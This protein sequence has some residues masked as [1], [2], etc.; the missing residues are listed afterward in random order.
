MKF[1]IDKNLSY[2]LK[3]ILEEDFSGTLHIDNVGLGTATD[4]EV[5]TFALQNGYTIITKDNDFDVLSNMLG[6]PP[7]VVHLVCGNISTKEIGNKLF[8]H[9]AEIKTLLSGRECLLK[10]S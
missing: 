5:W 4:R 8:S 10:V 6:C 7:K 2:K 9:R 1:L 3:L